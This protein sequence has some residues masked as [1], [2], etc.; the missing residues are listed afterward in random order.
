[1]HLVSTSTGKKSFLENIVESMSRPLQNYVPLQNSSAC[2]SDD[3]ACEH[4][5]SIM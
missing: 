3:A 1:M 2:F 5:V 4:H